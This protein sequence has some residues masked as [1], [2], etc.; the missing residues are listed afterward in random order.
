M[1]DF[2]PIKSSVGDVGA[3][4]ERVF[5][6]GEDF[7]LSEGDYSGYF[8]HTRL[9]ATVDGLNLTEELGVYLD[10]TERNNVGVSGFAAWLCVRGLAQEKKL[11]EVHVDFVRWRDNYKKQTKRGLIDYGKFGHD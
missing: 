4:I 7:A 10:E 2:W 8:V 11:A 5:S 9:V 1:T 3:N 6:A